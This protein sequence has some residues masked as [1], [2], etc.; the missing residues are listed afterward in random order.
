M[1]HSLGESVNNVDAWALP[2]ESLMVGSKMKPSN[3]HFKSVPGDSDT[4]HSL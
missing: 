3:I 1:N 4:V 2:P